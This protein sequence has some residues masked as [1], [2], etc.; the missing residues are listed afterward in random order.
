MEKEIDE[1]NLEEF[2]KKY[3]NYQED[4]VTRFLIEEEWKK[5][6]TSSF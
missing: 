2:I 5:E 1:E 6:R 3:R 4:I